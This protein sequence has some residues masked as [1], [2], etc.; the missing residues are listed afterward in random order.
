MAHAVTQSAK[1]KVV[2]SGGSKT[3]DQEFLTTVR[4]AMDAGANG[5]AVGRNVFQRDNPEQILDGLEA[6]IFENAT[7]AEALDTMGVEPTN[8]E[9]LYWP[10][11]PASTRQNSMRSSRRWPNS[12]PR[13]G[14]RYRVAASKAMRST[15]PAK[16]DWRP[17]PTPT[18]SSRKLSAGSTASAPTPARSRPNPSMSAPATCRSP[19]TPLMA[20]RISSPTARWERSSRSTRATSRPAVT[21][22]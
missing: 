1:S 18:N 4:N 17:T 3:D 22:C 14:R 9:A 5:L 21:A 12:P 15:P 7:V 6:V 19:A 8:P 20:H 16:R 13:S 10:P 2:M 11:I